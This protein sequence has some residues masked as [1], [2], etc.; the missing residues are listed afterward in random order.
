M[1]IYYQSNVCVASGKWNEWNA[2]VRHKQ[3]NDQACLQMMKCRIRTSA[4]TSC[5]W[6]T[7]KHAKRAVY[8]MIIRIASG[9]F[10]RYDSIDEVN[11]FETWSEIRI[12]KM[13]SWFF[14][15][16]SDWKKQFRTN[17]Q[18]LKH[19]EKRIFRIKYIETLANFKREK[20]EKNQ[21]RKMSW[22]FTAISI[23]WAV[24]V[25]SFGLGTYVFYFD[26]YDAMF[27]CLLGKFNQS[28]DLFH[29]LKSLL[30]LFA[31]VNIVASVSW[32]RGADKVSFLS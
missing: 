2:V 12:N 25:S 10:L 21:T 20:F 1:N 8:L 23:G 29:S 19:C 28:I 6:E 32:L 22:R 27:I 5:W 18:R 16:N 13:W 15:W 24:L 7:N 11:E 26:E 31:A 4:A 17:S 3:T 30:K 14:C 9:K